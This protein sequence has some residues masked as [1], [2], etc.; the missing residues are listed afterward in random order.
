MSAVQLFVLLTR[1]IVVSLGDVFLSSKQ[2]K[3]LHV[4]PV[5]TTSV[6]NAAAQLL[7]LQ[8]TARSVPDSAYPCS[9]YSESLRKTM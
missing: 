1:Q 2:Q 3:G 9:S 7:H 5:V 4:N 8:K 6:W